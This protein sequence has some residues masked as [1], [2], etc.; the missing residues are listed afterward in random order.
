MVD[1][2]ADLTHP[3]IVPN[4]WMN[5]VE[6]AGPGANAAN[7]YKNGLD[8]DGDGEE[9]IQTDSDAHS[10]CPAVICTMQQSNGLGVLSMS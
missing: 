9:A 3:D 1:T 2:G 5:P 8:D 4:L 7:G 6:M 10:F